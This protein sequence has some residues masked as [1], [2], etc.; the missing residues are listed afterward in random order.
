[1]IEA[2]AITDIIRH[3]VSHFQSE[4]N[5]NIS[6]LLDHGHIKIL[7]IITTNMGYYRFFIF[8]GA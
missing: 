3:R 6:T 7:T 8:S 2:V 4:L 5:Y 1:M